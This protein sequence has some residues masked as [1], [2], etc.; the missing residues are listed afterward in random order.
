MERAVKDNGQ[1]LNCATNV[2]MLAA[3]HIFLYIPTI[4]LQSLLWRQGL[5]NS[6]PA[7][8]EYLNTSPAIC[9]GDMHHTKV[10]DCNQAMTFMRLVSSTS[11]IHNKRD[12]TL[13]V[14]LPVMVLWKRVQAVYGQLITGWAHRTLQ[15]VLF[16]CWTFFGYAVFSLI[17]KLLISKIICSLNS[18]FPDK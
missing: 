6:C 7:L 4:L 18:K 12:N 17:W 8:S 16:C 10:N 15:Y 11:P 1:N 9:C 5:H 3:M 13:C 14:L 2:A